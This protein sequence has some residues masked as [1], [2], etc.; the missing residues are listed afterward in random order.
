[1]DTEVSMSL[2]YALLGLL[3]AGSASGYELT[4]SFEESLERYAWSAQQSHIYPELK[5]LERA[6]HITVVDR[7][8]RGRQT[9]GITA[10]GRDVLRSWLRTASS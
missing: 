7:G 1:M 2:T 3:D 10:S 6:G 8:A 4:K 5:R 9:Y